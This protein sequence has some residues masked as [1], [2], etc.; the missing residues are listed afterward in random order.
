MMYLYRYCGMST[1]FGTK[2]ET[3]KYKKMGKY[4]TN[5]FKDMIVDLL[6]SGQRPVDIS[7]EYEVSKT[8]LRDWKKKR[9]ENPDCFQGN[10]SGKITKEQLELRRARQK[11]KD[12]TLERDILKIVGMSRATDNKS[13]RA[14]SL[15]FSRG[16]KFF[17]G[18]RGISLP[19]T[20]F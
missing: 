11:L 6:E 1:N 15:F 12:I 13:S 18:G 14:T 7:R 4:Y 2:L 10:G 16:K 19:C 9:K 20:W 8:V 17:R 3:L 5:D